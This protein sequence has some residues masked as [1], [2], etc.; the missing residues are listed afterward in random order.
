MCC[1]LEQI[2]HRSRM[3]NCTSQEWYINFNSNNLG[4]ISGKLSDNF[5]TILQFW[6]NFG[7]TSRTTLRQR[8][9]SAPYRSGTTTSR[10]STQLERSAGKRT[11]S[12]IPKPFLEKS[13]NGLF[14]YSYIFRNPIWRNRVITSLHIPGVQLLWRRQ[15]EKMQELVFNA[16]DTNKNGKISFRS[17]NLLF[18]VL[19]Y[20]KHLCLCQGMVAGSLYLPEG[21]PRRKAGL[22]F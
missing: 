12:Y 9:K 13:G 3:K 16:L 4:T 7:I 19:E 21:N 1:D 2:V 17:L 20:L 22:D 18:W 5:W 6:G 14:L 8:W 15:T 11:E 10:R